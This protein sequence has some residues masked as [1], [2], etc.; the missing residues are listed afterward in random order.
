MTHWNEKLIDQ[1]TPRKASVITPLVGY[2]V[3]AVGSLAIWG[4]VGAM[5]LRAL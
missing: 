1:T 2:G 3:A 5:V 4:M